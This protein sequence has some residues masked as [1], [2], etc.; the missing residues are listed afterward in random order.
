M[1]ATRVALADWHAE[2]EAARAAG[3]T[4][5]AD[6]AAV[7]E[8]GVSDHIRVVISLLDP[9]SGARAELETL[10]DRDGGE[11]ADVSDLFPG[12]AWLQRQIHDLFAIGI[13]DGDNRPLIIHGPPGV[14]RK[15]VLLAPRQET[16]WPGALEPGE[17]DASPSRRKLVPPGV[18]DPAVVADPASTPADIALS[19]TGTRVRGRR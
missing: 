1:S 16:R 18:P 10:V 8:V 5:L 19:A 2:V 15:D 17:S 6:L 9:D 3:A 4:F 12:A 14:L 13:A 7:D 11:I